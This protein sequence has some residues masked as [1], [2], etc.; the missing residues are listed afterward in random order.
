M[1]FGWDTR[2]RTRTKTTKMSCATITP[3]PKPERPSVSRGPQTGCAACG[4]KGTTKF[5]NATHSRLFF[6]AS[7]TQITTLRRWKPT[8]PE[9]L[10]W[11]S[12]AAESLRRKRRQHGRTPQLQPHEKASPTQQAATAAATHKKT[13][14]SGVRFRGSP[15]RD[16]PLSVPRAG[17]EPARVAPS[18]FETDASTDSAIWAENARRRICGA[19]VNKTSETR[20]LNPHFFSKIHNSAAPAQP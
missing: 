16:A 12:N 8:P 3:Y 2:F 20:A 10:R 18:V 19:K 13:S 1:R 14:R 7:D 11:E 5:R 4:C 15:L 6:F 17:V 9:S